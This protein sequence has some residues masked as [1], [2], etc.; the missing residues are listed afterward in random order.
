MSI[1]EWSK[2]EIRRRR[3]RRRRKA[4]KKE[5]EGEENE[6]NVGGYENLNGNFKLRQLASWG[7]LFFFLLSLP[8]FSLFLSNLPFSFFFFLSFFV[9]FPCIG[10]HGRIIIIM[11]IIMRH[12]TN[13]KNK[14]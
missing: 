8:F 3:K 10:Y 12:L 6:G 14:K 11:M 7:L 4:K 2:C 5:E 9:Q 1:E 13:R